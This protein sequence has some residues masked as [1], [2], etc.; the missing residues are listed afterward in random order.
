MANLD[1]LDRRLLLE[2]VRDP[3]A[4]I[5]ELSERLGVAR[6]TA[7]AHVRH[8]LRA[9]V[10]RRSGRDVDLTQLG[11]DVQAFVTIEVNHREL[12]G[13]I[14]GLRTLP[15]VLEVHEIS[16]RGD[17]WCRLTATDTQQLQQALRSVL[18][19][20]GVI[21]T[22][23]VLALHEHIPYRTEPLLEKLVPPAP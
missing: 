23:T 16:G 8:L 22:E 15:Q 4:Q 12:D 13:V 19:I 6:N 14:S 18:R 21:R 11:Y 9:G 20:K 1:P 3:R 17:V 2:L 7:Q 5:S 10:I